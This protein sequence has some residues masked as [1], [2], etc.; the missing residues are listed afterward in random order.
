L[1]AERHPQHLP[2]NRTIAP[3]HRQG[4]SGKC[5]RTSSRRRSL[6]PTILFFTSARF[7]TNV[8][9]RS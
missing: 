5:K 7:T 2:T 3:G 6:S 8:L 1:Q 9:K 4:V